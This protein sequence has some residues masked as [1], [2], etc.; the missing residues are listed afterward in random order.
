MKHRHG[1]RHDSSPQ[2]LIGGEHDVD[3]ERLQT[4][5][6]GNAS[7]SEVPGEALLDPMPVR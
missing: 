1:D 4:F 2:R 7:A 5:C 3:R 6:L